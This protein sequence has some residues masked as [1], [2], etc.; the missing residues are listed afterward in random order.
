MSRFKLDKLIEKCSQKIVETVC[1][2]DNLST[3]DEVTGIIHEHFANVMN[4]L[5]KARDVA[6][7]W[8]IGRDT[9]AMR[10]E[11]KCESCDGRVKRLAEML[12]T[13]EEE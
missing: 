4:A 12:E 11:H 5:G 7:G 1:E 6:T 2:H 10:K 3:Q 8:E 9:K 13:L